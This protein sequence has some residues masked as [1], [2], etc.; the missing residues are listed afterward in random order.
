[1]NG[2]ASDLCSDVSGQH[3]HPRDPA[4]SYD[5]GPCA[6]TQ[7]ISPVITSAWALS[8]G[9]AGDELQCVALIEAMG[10][11]PDIRRVSPRAP[12][13]WLMPWGPIAPTETPGNAA[14]PIAGPF[15]DLV[16]ASGRRAVAYVRAIRKYS[17][18]RTFTVILKDPRTGCGAADFIW[19]PE[20]DALRAPNV[21]AT[22]T[23][24]HRLSPQRLAQAR[25]SVGSDLAVL[26]AP[27][28]AVLVGGNSRRHHYTPE[29]IQD[30][31]DRLASLAD[32]GV[33][34]MVTASRRTPADLAEAVRTVVA[35]RG[36]YFWD[37]DGDNPYATIMALADVVVVTTDSTNML[38]EAAATGK[39]VLTFSPGPDDAKTSLLLKALKARSV[40]HEFA[41]TLAGDAYP[42]LN[43]TPIIAE[44]IMR[45]YAEKHANITRSCTPVQSVT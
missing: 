40:V 41:G 35:Q 26:P 31:C 6:G 34:L 37:G 45:A 27:R 16:V 15:P 14:S 30:F 44:A 43:S 22:L 20:H 19:V 29:A 7:S 13:L 24:P 2:Q 25:A 28:A 33:A 32:S 10:L 9:K 12:W 4:A 5:Q 42:P 17:G 23:S 11:T 38:G 18:G 8:D 1:M 39:P 36:G 3:L 21:M